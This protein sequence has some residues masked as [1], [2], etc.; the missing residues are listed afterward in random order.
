M[1]PTAA[2]RSETPLPS[3]PLD[4]SLEADGL[5]VLERNFARHGDAFRIF[6]P[7]LSRQI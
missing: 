7:L 4:V 6:S 2:T 1:N 3:E 5:T